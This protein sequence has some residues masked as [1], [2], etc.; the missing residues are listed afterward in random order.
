MTLNTN[1]TVREIAVEVPSATRVFEKLGIDY[2]CGGAKNFREACVEAK[3]PVD[4]VLRNLQQAEELR[5]AR[6]ESARDWNSA[7]L[8]EVIDEIVRKHHAYVQAEIPRV[9]ALAE[10]VSSKHGDKHPE[11][12]KVY[13]LFEALAN[14]LTLHLMKEEQILFPYITRM[15]ESN[16]EKSPV[17][18]SC[19]GSV[20]N[21]V[22]MMMMEHD[23]A[24]TVLKELRDATGDYK[25][26]E[27]ACTS[28]R[29]LYN[30][31][32]EFEA[33]LHQHIHMENN[34]LFPRAVAM[35][36]QR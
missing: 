4:E 33:D 11:T 18:P 15:E 13:E 26:P 14:E 25:L 35:E 1:R 19:F 21:P 8:S 3:I 6:Q 2:C 24:G 22:R 29:T 23:N 17:V 36:E 16:I 30:A 28:Y 34:I 5:L 10:K 27:D 20:H 12:K 32:L 31:L 9:S 7:P